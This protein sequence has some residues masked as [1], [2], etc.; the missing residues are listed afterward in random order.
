[1]LRF[2]FFLF[3]FFSALPSWAQFSILGKITDQNFN[4][5]PFITVKISG[6]QNRI[7]YAQTDSLGNYHLKNLLRG[8]YSVIFSALNFKT[9]TGSLN[10]TADTIINI[11]LAADAQILTD[12]QINA[13]QPLITQK[14]DRTVFNVENSIAAIG[15]DAL[16][17]LAKVPGVRVLND[18][19]SLVGKGSVSVMIDDKLVQLS[20]DNLSGYLKSISSD[21]IGKIEIITNPPAK[22]DAQGNNGLINI[23][24]KKAL[25]DG[26]KVSVIAGINQATYATAV[27]GGNLNYRKNKFTVYTNLNFR[28]GSLVPVEQSNIYYPTQQWEVVNKDRNF[29]TV[30]SGQFGVDYQFSKRG[31]FGASYAGGLTNFHS[32][33][34]I[35]TTVFNEK[36]Q[37]DSMLKSDANAKIRSHYHSANMYLKQLLNTAGKTFTFNADW[38]R[39]ND[40]KNRFF[41]NTSYFPNDQPV[42]D[43]FAEYLSASKQQTALYTVK[44]DFDLPYPFLK[45]AVGGKISFI[46]NKSD[47]GFFKRG[48]GTYVLDEKQSNLF[49]YRENTQALYLN[50][51]KN[52][53]RWDFQFGLRGEYS[54]MDGVS[55]NERNQNRYFQLFPTA[56]I[57]YRASGQSIWSVNY[58]RRINRPAYRKLNPFRWYSNQYVYTEGNPFL[59][60][61]YNNNISLM[62][63]YKQVFTTTFSFSK[64]ADG[65]ND[66]NFVDSL[67]NT[68]SSKP[69]NFVTGY[70][71]QLSNSVVLNPLKAWE[72]TNQLN[73][74][75]NIANSSLPQT[76]SRL[77]GFGAYFASTN[78]F[79]LN[80][81]KT[82][83]GD[84]S[85]WYAWP[86]V[87]GVNKSRSQYNLDIGFKTLWLD[88][89][90]QIAL[91]A[92]DILKTDR[93]RFSSLVNG[94]NQVYNHYYDNRQLRFSVRY[95]FGN[96]KIKRQEI[97][98][99][100]EDE[101]RRNN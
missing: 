97:K 27:A 57:N 21:N 71:Y 79:I 80:R 47:V 53:K 86:A 76:L 65:Y 61:S 70:H 28:K 50:V 34:Q 63:I 55:V 37:I 52:I 16:E 40:D 58:G 7:S 98:Q 78:Q 19:V 56:F 18:K 30:P 38:F 91:A 74:F 73:I 10:L 48:E 94:I 88:K 14:I 89:K 49:N 68:Q 51:S 24:L 72:S 5:L 22:Y 36:E 99:G 8:R 45:I 85:F 2:S 6:P 12:V 59:K 66:L 33:E 35:N 64:T 31:T 69:V 60:P 11:Q 93:Y 15:T 96:E 3:A 54:Q 17:L 39:Y 41:D 77:K 9:T 82:V 46:Q 87:D 81:S 67:S 20:G 43:S 92:T 23:V 29:R 1:M 95:N 101:R 83:L 25:G 26:I 44:A 4:A 84:I 13:K 100:N 62:H 90:L 75:Y 32:E 42:P